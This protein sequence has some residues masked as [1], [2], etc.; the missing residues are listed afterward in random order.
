M[1]LPLRDHNP[2]TH[3]PWITLGLIA[4]NVVVFLRELGAG[5]DTHLL[6]AR[7]GATPYEL[8]HLD[9]LVGRVQGSGLVHVEGP[10]LL[11]VTAITSMF[12]HGGWLHLLMNMHFLWIFGNNVEDALGSLRYLAFYLATGLLGLLAHVATDPNSIIPT[13]GASG[14][15]SGM[16]GAYL[17]LYPRARV[18]TLLFLGFFVSYIE[19]RAVLLISVWTL[20]QVL[21][22]LVGLTV[23][24]MA[25]G[26]AYWA[27]IGGFVAGYVGMRL[28][29]RGIVLEVHAADAWRRSATRI[30]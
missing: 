16:L 22:G 7:W 23:S 21:S 9:D 30:P 25:G 28:L 5:P 2:T 19:V 15:I 4:V 8:T 24:G 13:V 29:F 1:F 26:V 27:H 18:T 3:V 6:L 12:L 14:A 10:P 17:V 11:W 20:L